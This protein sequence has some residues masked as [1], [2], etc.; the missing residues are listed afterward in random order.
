MFVIQKG[1]LKVHEVPVLMCES[2][3]THALDLVELGVFHGELSEEE[4]YYI[5]RLVGREQWQGQNEQP[6]KISNN[7][8]CST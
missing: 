5:F 8:P 3:G 4:R 6:S 7:I 1:I 2:Y